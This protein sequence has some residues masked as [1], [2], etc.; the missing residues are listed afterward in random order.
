MINRLPLLRSLKKNITSKIRKERHYGNMAIRDKFEDARKIINIPNPMIVDGG[1]HTGNTTKEFLKKFESPEIFAFEAI[2]ELSVKLSNRFSGTQG[3]TVFQ[4]AIGAENR[5]VK[6]NILK[7]T[8]SSSILTPTEETFKLHGGESMKT[9]K[10]LDVDMVRL[11]SILPAGKNIDILKLDLQGYELEALKGAIGILDK[12]KIIISEV[13]FI[14][15]YNGQP[16][17]SDLD[18]FLR[19]KGFRLFNFY[20]LYTFPNGQ[21]DAGDALFIREDIARNLPL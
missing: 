12:V 20:H 8:S 18:I 7:H 15:L 9:E 11:D 19:N 13:E 4:K 17:F 16:L 21:M 10:I 6:F 3:V 1:A 14:P 2:P 5:K